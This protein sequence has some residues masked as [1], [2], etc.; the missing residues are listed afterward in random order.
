MNYWWFSRNLGLI[1]ASIE[2]QISASSLLR[3]VYSLGDRAK[4]ER[5]HQRLASTLA[6]FNVLSFC[7]QCF[8]CADRFLVSIYPYYTGLGVST[9]Q[10]ARRIVWS[11]RTDKKGQNYYTS[12]DNVNVQ[13]RLINSIRN[14]GEWNR[15][16]SYLSHWH[17]MTNES[18][19]LRNCCRC[20]KGTNII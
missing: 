19:L 5:H 8:L 13:H 12:K 15:W 20:L 4:I 10:G 14:F 6:R 17:K 3:V 2:E 18:K 9:V 1:L 16:I 11:N 7:F